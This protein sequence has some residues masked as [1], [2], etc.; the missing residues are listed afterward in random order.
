MNTVKEPQDIMSW[1]LKAPP[2]KKAVEEDARLL[3]IAGR[4]VTSHSHLYNGC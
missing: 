2:S 3:L 1:L 4:Y